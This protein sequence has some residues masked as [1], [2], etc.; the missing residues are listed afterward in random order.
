MSSNRK[1]AAEREK[2]LRLAIFRIETGRSHTQ[3]KSLTVAS[4][5]KEAG[6][7]TA[8]IYNH[9]EAVAECIRQK[10]G[11]TSKAQRDA[12]AQELKEEQ[13]KSKQLRSDLK[14]CQFKSKALASINEMLH[15]ELDVLRAQIAGSNIQILSKAPKNPG[16]R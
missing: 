4:V 7:S 15:D 3:P 2:D 16:V 10:Q 8:L 14:E 9:Y 5:A 6:V 11:K 1:S 13:A 12:K